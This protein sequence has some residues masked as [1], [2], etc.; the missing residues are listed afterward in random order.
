MTGV[1]VRAA[2]PLDAPVVAR[3]IALLG[4]QIEP[5]MVADRLRELTDM[6]QLVAILDREIVGLCGLHLMRAIH[7]DRPVGRITILVI[8]HGHRGQGIGRALV[9]EAIRYFRDQGCELLEVTSNNRLRDAHGFYAVMGF[10]QTSTRFALN[11]D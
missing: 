10:E 5:G 9:E 1:R 8:D 11:L 7:R 6:P 2:T 3:L 4:H